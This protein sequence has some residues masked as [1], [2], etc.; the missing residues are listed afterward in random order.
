GTSNRLNTTLCDA[1]LQEKM[2]IDIVAAS[3]GMKLVVGSLINFLQYMIHI[4]MLATLARMFTF[5][6]VGWLDL[7]HLLELKRFI[8]Y[9]SFG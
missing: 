4:Y 8:H 9:Q 5:V 1:F 6:V 2:I 3:F 7:Y